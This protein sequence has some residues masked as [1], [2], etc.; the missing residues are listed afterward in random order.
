MRK[1][2]KERLKKIVEAVFEDM[3]PFV[4]EIKKI[5]EEIE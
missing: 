3:D 5:L 1:T 2:D 4:L